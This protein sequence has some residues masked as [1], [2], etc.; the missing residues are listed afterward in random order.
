MPGQGLKKEARKEREVG[1]RD[2]IYTLRPVMV[3][4]QMREEYSR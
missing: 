3:D 4:V 2:S 1:N